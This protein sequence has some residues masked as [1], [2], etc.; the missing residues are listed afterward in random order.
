MTYGSAARRI[1]PLLLLAGA[2]TV[3]TAVP[4][5]AENPWGCRA[6]IERAV[7]RYDMAVDRFGPDSARADKE[8]YT[9]TAIK[10]KCYQLF[11]QWWEP[12]DRRW[13]REHW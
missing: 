5:Q 6:K 12:H 11:G 7:A 9:V 3:M 10:Q 13:H 4:V 2:L 1:A 8:R